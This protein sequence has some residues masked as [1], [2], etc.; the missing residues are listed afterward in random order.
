M[1][2][3]SPLG[4]FEDLHALSLLMV[5]AARANDWD[6]L[7]AHERALAAARDRLIE[8][9]ARGEIAEPSEPAALARKAALLG[10]MQAHDAEIRRHVE[11]WM[12]SARKLL[13]KRTRGRVADQVRAA[14][15]AHGP[16]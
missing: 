15:G 4:P 8:A 10:D 11:P 5:Q 1:K 12:G 13:G 3:V 9:Q 2:P 14:Y 16:R 7:T 6:A